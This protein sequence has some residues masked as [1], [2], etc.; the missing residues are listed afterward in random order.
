MY[1]SDWAK[2]TIVS[3]LWYKTL[4]LIFYISFFIMKNPIYPGS[5]DP[6]TY[7]HMDI[8]QRMLPFCERLILAIGIN[9]AKDGKY[10]FSLQERM[11]MI[12]QV[13]ADE[14]KIDVLAFR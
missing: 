7:G 6:I 8:A 3:S 13:F 5:F 12:R 9:P 4:F 10:M 14:E 1:C 2:R 11:Q